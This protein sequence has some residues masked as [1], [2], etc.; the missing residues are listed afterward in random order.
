LGL[1]GAYLTRE[2][3][4]FL[5]KVAV[6]GDIRLITELYINKYSMTTMSH[7]L[8]LLKRMRALKSKHF[9]MTPYRFICLSKYYRELKRYDWY[10]KQKESQEVKN[11]LT[12]LREQRKERE[13]KYKKELAK[14]RTPIDS[15]VDRT[16][17]T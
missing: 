7:L 8:W 10:T 14:R 11:A 17:E 6:L 1:K 3:R 12:Y 9:L 5:R 13:E 16:H 4:A 15:K 2:E